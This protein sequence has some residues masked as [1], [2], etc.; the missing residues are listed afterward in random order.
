MRQN[1]Y[2]SSLIPYYHFDKNCDIWSLLNY[3][4]IMITAKK[5]QEFR[6]KLQKRARRRAEK[7]IEI[8]EEDRGFKDV[9]IEPS[10]CTRLQVTFERSTR[11]IN[12]HPPV[13][14]LSERA[15]E[16]QRTVL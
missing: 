16:P 5:R 4:G 6:I 2:C 10:D 14:L 1:N 9:C 15:P 3:A 13:T 12:I 11:D 7:K 8:L